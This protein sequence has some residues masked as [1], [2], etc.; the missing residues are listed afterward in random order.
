MI[1]R[2]VGIGH[3]TGLLFLA[4]DIRQPVWHRGFESHRITFKIKG[5][6]MFI[7]RL[8]RG[9]LSPIKIENGINIMMYYLKRKLHNKHYQYQSE[10]YI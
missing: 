9:D 2:L 5:C 1:R 4:Y 3:L 10:R 8:F 6:K 7:V